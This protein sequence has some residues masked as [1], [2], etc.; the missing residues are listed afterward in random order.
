MRKWRVNLIRGEV[1]DRWPSG[2]RGQLW[3][4]MRPI[5]RQILP[6]AGFITSIKEMDSTPTSCCFALTRKDQ[7]RKNRPKQGLLLEFLSST[8]GLGE[9]SEGL[10]CHYSFPTHMACSWAVPGT[11]TTARRMVKRSACLSVVHY[12]YWMRIKE[13]Y[14]Y[15]LVV[16]I[17]EIMKGH[18]TADWFRKEFRLVDFLWMDRGSR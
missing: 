10:Y 3:I 8:T 7:N 4:G 6:P 11:P 14:G 9:A 15:V 16:R 12:G 17:L 13:V 5:D 2:A 1:D 18:W